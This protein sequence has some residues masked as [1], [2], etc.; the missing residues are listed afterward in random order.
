[1]VL[2][3]CTNIKSSWYQLTRTRDQNSHVWHFIYSDQLVYVS[4]IFPKHGFYISRGKGLLFRFSLFS[5]W[6]HT[7]PPSLR[8]HISEATLLGYNAYLY[9]LVKGTP[10][11]STR[12]SIWLL[13]G[14][15]LQRIYQIHLRLD[16]YYIS[17]FHIHRVHI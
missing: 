9:M 7:V 14:H 15:E 8:V 2:S 12:W 13:F 16:I 17:M 11:R 4:G 1:M 3:V 6:S 5:E 10:L